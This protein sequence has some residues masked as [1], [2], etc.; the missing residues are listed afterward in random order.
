MDDYNRLNYDFGEANL[1]KETIFGSELA[2]VYVQPK[3]TVCKPI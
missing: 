2:L 3:P 1:G